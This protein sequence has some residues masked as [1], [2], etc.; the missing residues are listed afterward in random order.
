[1]RLFVAVDL[2][3]PRRLAAGRAASDLARR[4]SLGRAVKW[5]EPRNLHLTIR[6]IGEADE[7]QARRIQAALDP[8][9]LTPAFDFALGGVGVFPPGGSPR[10]LWLGV[11]HGAAALADLHDEVEGRLQAIGEPPE[12]RGFSAHLTLARFKDLDRARGEWVRTALREIRFEAGPCRIEAITL[13]Q[14]GL[15]P[16]GP[17]HTPLLRSPLAR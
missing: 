15:A 4:L 13:Y 1:M 8:A 16:S 3:E 12:G 14:S 7:S 11:V 10:V 6:F 2:D 5:V 9:L 17:T